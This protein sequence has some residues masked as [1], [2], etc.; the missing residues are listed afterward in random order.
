MFFSARDIQTKLASNHVQ[1]RFGGA[2]VHFEKANIEEVSQWL[3]AGESGININ[4]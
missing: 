3:L 1:L 2:A 4:L